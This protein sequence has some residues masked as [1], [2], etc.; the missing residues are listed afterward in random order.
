MK[1]LVVLF[2]VLTGYSYSQS[3]YTMTVDKTNNSL[4]VYYTDFDNVTYA[5]AKQ[6][7]ANLGSGWRIPT[8]QESISMSIRKKRLKI[9]DSWYWCKSTDTSNP[10]WSCNMT[11]GSVFANYGSRNTCD[12]RPVKD[13]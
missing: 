7:C 8:K 9:K 2:I 13:M 1:T 10:A 6:I 11:I 3:N 4:Y 12:F 5:E